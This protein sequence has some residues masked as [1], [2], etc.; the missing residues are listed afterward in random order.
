MPELDYDTQ[1]Y[2][3][4]AVFTALIMYFKREMFK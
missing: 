2:L 1:V 4:F 3:G